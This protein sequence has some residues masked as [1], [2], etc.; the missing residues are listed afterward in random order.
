MRLVQDQRQ[1]D[2]DGAGRACVM[3]AVALHEEGVEHPGP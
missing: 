3:T 2:G 1:R